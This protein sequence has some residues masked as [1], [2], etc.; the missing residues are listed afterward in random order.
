MDRREFFATVFGNGE[1]RA[2]MVLPNH[3]GKPTNDHWFNYPADVDKMVQFAEEHTTKDVWFSPILYTEDRRTKETSKVVS[4]AAADADS[5]DPGNFRMAP[6]I[7]VQTSDGHWHVYWALS[8]PADPKTMAKLNRRIAQVHKH[9]GCDTAFVNAAKLLR[10]PETS[11]S[12]H[13]GAV[14]IISDLDTDIS[15]TEAQLNKLY[16]EE[17]IPDAIDAASVVM[18]D[19]LAEY[20]AANRASL[21][22]GLPNS[23]AI[24]QL[25]FGN[26]H[27]DKRSEVLYRLCCELYR[28]GLDDKD[29][30]A[31]AWGAPSNKFN[32]EDPRG[33]SGLWTTAVMRAKNDVENESIVDE[34]DK[35][36]VEFYEGSIRQAGGEREGLRDPTVFLTH[37][38]QEIVRNN[39]NFID[40]WCSWASSKT[41]AP[42][43]YHRAA[44]I[45]VLSTVY[46]QFGYILPSFGK[47]KLNVWMLLLGR[48]TKDRKSTASSYALRML[49]KLSDEE[50][51]Y[52]LPD[53]STP[54]GLNIALLDRENLSSLLMRDEAQGFFEEMLKQS[55][56]AGGISYFTKLYDGWSGGR[57]R[58]S[59]DKK[60]AHSVPISFV[61]FLLGILD[62]SAE[63]LTIRNYKQGFLT[64]FLYVIGERP[65]GYEEPEIEFLE[66]DFGEEEDTVFNA[67][68]RR[69][70]ATRN[71]WDM[72]RPD[73]D[74]VKLNLTP[75]AADRWRQFKKDVSEL[76][77]SSSY[78]EIIDSTSDRMTL[79]TL[80]VAALLAMD[81]RSS[82]VE[83][84]HVLQAIH[85]A[86]EWFDNSIRVASM[87]S[88]SE[89]QRDVDKLEQFINAKGGKVSYGAAYR[90]FNDKRPF[91]FEE[92][93]SALEGRGVLTRERHGGRWVL[94]VSYDE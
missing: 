91:E 34:Y 8:A 82:K 94:I 64:R 87:I 63:V 6:T 78:A 65:E 77:K 36:F 46:S 41:D 59:G 47:L 62:D 83:L 3:A 19:D 72:R 93:L 9:E 38:E 67:M 81:D 18:P 35:P 84:R 11:N 69:L 43:E 4:V 79:S 50:F 58:A 44:A 20:I 76:A 23:L 25:L 90:A 28:I 33:L 7:S 37:E 27:E 68:H 48:S 74:M 39:V 29:V 13:P 12:K 21:L 54:G 2:V 88:E 14:V 16:S 5:C 75:E 56:M 22:Q 32:G 45:T 17:E 66:D 1:G 71:Y 49:R 31:I 53:D 80:K 85:Y 92:M 89:W 10:V 86:G 57:A 60:I 73:N 26:F 61:F 55:Y 30:A 40:E 51:T 52:I 24:R 70:A 15:Y 42:V